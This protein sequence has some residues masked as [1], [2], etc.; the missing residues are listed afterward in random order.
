MNMT[1]EEK[2][3]SKT[4]EK[5]GSKHIEVEKEFSYEKTGREGVI[6]ACLD[7]GKKSLIYWDIGD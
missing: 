5:C 6:T 7:C 2:K 3:R 1:K 4:C